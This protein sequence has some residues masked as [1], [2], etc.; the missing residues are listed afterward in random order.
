MFMRKNMLETVRTVAGAPLAAKSAPRPFASAAALAQDDGG[1]KSLGEFFQTVARASGAPARQDAR[2]VRAPTGLG[3]LDETG[4]GFAVPPVFIETLGGSMFEDAV[5]ASRCSRFESASPSD[6]SIP[7]VDETSRADG[8]RWGGATSYWAIEGAAVASSLPKWRRV[9]F[10]G[11]KLF[12]VCA[13]TGELIADA[14]MLGSYLTR[15]FAAEMSFKLDTAI[16]RGSGEG[17]P[18]GFISS[19]ALITV[20]KDSGQATQTISASNIENMWAALPVSCRRRAVWLC[21]EKVETQLSSLQA[22]GLSAAAAAIYMP[23]GVNDDYPRLKG[24]PLIAIEQAEPVGT[25]GDLLL[26]DLSQYAIVDSGF[27]MNLSLDVDFTSDQGVFRFVLR[28]D[29]KPL[30]SSSVTSYSDASPRSPFVALAAR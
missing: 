18:L 30:W 15:A 4:G 21:H 14:P 10:A 24:R 23:T 1:F 16:I 11:H 3:E 6:T 13:A 29:G 17:V 2:L 27:K 20:A 26:A 8:S 7:G 22:P 25:V 5:I 12:A 9:E 28:I 19:P